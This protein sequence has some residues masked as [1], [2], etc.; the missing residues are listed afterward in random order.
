MFNKIVQTSRNF[1]PFIPPSISHYRSRFVQYRNR[2][3]RRFYEKS[4]IERFGHSYSSY[5]ELLIPAGYSFTVRS[6]KSSIDSTF[7]SRSGSGHLRICI[8]GDDGSVTIR[9]PHR[10]A[11]NGRR[12][13][14]DKGGFTVACHAA[15]NQG[16]FPLA[17]PCH[18]GRQPS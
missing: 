10:F 13:W 12:G 7:D 5:S 3:L 4:R 18:G 8:P 17:I 6:S 9:P 14:E 16:G 11:P 1:S 2:N 15:S